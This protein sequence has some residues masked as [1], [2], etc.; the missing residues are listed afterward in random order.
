MVFLL[1]QLADHGT[2]IKIGR[3]DSNDG[4]GWLKK[5]PSPSGRK[6]QEAIA[7]VS[8]RASMISCRW[9]RGVLN[10]TFSSLHVPP[11]SRLSFLL[12]RSIVQYTTGF[13]GW[14]SF[15]KLGWVSRVAHIREVNN[16]FCAW[17]EGGNPKGCSEVSFAWLQPSSDR[18]ILT[19]D[20]TL[21]PKIRAASYSKSSTST[22][23]EACLVGGLLE[24]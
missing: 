16:F 4:H 9:L 22:R 19:L 8:C 6:K 23:D 7:L 15:R 2:N 10:F 18:H 20:G 5:Q 13:V 21:P 14:L 3:C 1:K 17:A 24:V 11:R 12:R